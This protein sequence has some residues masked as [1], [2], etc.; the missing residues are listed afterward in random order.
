MKPGDDD[1]TACDGI[2][3]HTIIIESL[4]KTKV[5]VRSEAFHNYVIDNYGDADRKVGTSNLSVPSRVIQRYPIPL[6][7]DVRRGDGYHGKWYTYR[8]RGVKKLK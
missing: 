6:G 5:G 3:R 8:R 4:I 7:G 2:P 1:E